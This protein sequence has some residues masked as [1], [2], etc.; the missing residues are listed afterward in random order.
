[1]RQLKAYILLFIF[2]CSSVLANAS[3][4]FCGNEITNMQWF[5]KA[6]CEHEKQAEMSCHSHCCS[7]PKN[8]TQNQINKEDCCETQQLVSDLDQ[9]S[10]E[11]NQSKFQIATTAVL[12]AF[13]SMWYTD[14][15]S[16]D[17]F[18]KFEAPPNSEVSLSKIQV[19]II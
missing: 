4:H 14:H 5:S 18:N 17:D 19:Y 12:L 13:W 10:H 11:V 15:L 16:T 3:V 2:V 7:K 8:Q 1:M 9:L 6:E